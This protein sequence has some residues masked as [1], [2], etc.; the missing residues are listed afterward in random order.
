[1]IVIIMIMVIIVMIVIVIMIII[2]FISTIITLSLFEILEIF[3]SIEMIFVV[4][5]G[6]I[7]AG[8]QER[9]EVEGDSL[10]G[11]F[12]EPGEEASG[13]SSSVKVDWCLVVG[14]VELDSGEA[15]DA[16]SGDFVGGGVHLSDDEVGLGGKGLSDFDVGGSHSFTVAA[17]WG[18]VFDKD[19][20]VLIHDNVFPVEGNDF[21]DRLILGFGQGLT[22]DLLGKAAGLEIGDE[23]G[24]ALSGHISTQ[25]E[26]VHILFGGVDNPGLGST[27]RNA[28]ILIESSLELGVHSVSGSGVGHDDFTFE[29]IGDAS[30]VF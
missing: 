15:L 9:S 1:M 5:G 25:G 2:V 4:G 11:L 10:A 17:P 20:F 13:V 23:L 12:G 18:V 24:E 16:D 21:D 30:E 6:S 3:L 14:G 19:V 8:T 22:L 7:T 27:T 29:I 26:L 28:K